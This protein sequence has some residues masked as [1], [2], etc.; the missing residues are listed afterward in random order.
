MKPQFVITA[1]VTVSSKDGALNQSEE[2]KEIKVFPFEQ[3][4]QAKKATDGY[5]SCF[6]INLKNKISN[7]NIHNFTIKFENSNPCDGY[8]I[9]DCCPVRKRLKL[10][11]ADGY[12]S[13]MWA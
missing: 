13:Q 5:P 11:D 1:N 12:V 7:I 9:A 8:I 2:F 3:L 10:Y 6:V 4:F